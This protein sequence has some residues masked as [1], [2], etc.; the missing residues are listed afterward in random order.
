M[1]IRK[2]FRMHLRASH[3][4]TLGYDLLDDAGTVIGALSRFTSRSKKHKSN[5]VYTLLGPVNQEFASAGEFVAAYE[6]QNVQAQR[7]AEWDAADPEKK[8]N[9]V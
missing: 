1:A 5:D 9:Q 6:K 4:S 8:G 3:G 2:R 7:N